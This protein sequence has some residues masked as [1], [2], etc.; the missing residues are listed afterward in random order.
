MYKDNSLYKQTYS[1]G[2]NIYSVY[3]MHRY[4]NE[5]KEPIYEIPIRS[6]KHY[7]QYQ[8]WGDWSNPYGS[9]RWSISDVLKNKEKYQR[10]Y[11]NIQKA[12]LKFPI[13]TVKNPFEQYAILDGNHRL[14]KAILNKRKIIRGYVF[15]DPKLIKKFKIFSQTKKNWTKL[16]AMTKKDFDVLYGKRFK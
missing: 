10:D 14:G 15:T 5:H 16:D 12:N 2:N 4:V 3:M 11:K 13:V 1:D 8:I 6:F 7:I 9:D